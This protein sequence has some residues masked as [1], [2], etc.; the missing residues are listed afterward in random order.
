MSMRP[1]RSLVGRQDQIG[2]LQT[3]LGAAAQGEGGVL[4]LRGEPGIG[5]SALLDHL[6]GAVAAEFQIIRASGSE[7]ETELPFAALHQLCLPVLAH[8][9]GLTPPYRTAL[10]VAFGLA[11]GTPDPF[12]VGLGAL[13]LLAAA[14][15]ERPLVCVVDDAQWLDTASVRAL[16]F[17]ARR[18]AAEPIALL[19]AARP[20]GSARELERLPGLMVEGL[21]DAEAR[22][23][24]AAEKTVT[25]DERVRERILA[26]ARGNPLA[27]IEL[28][29]GGGFALPTPT[30]VA[31]RIAASFRARLSPLAAGARRLLL[32]AS[33]D[34]TGDPT[35]LWAAAQHVGIDL[36]A[37]GADAEASTL[38]EFDT[39]VRFCH[40]LARSAVYWAADQGRRNEAHRAL[41]EATDPVAAPDRRAWH[42]AQ[43]GTGPDE[44]VGA[45]PP[46]GGGAPARDSV[47]PGSAA[48]SVV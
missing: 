26:E 14:A 12:G 30:P 42:R 28:P 36:P 17:L 43:S 19:F 24:L 46:G 44:D 48:A 31:N 16:T 25:L 9:D 35:L 37:A 23:L 33:A 32:L 22:L 41:A 7:F 6:T 4:V 21:S 39:R 29:K 11:E 1:P 15:R 45:P 40:P 20:E 8:L 10:Q 5:K 38:V 3:V 27:L 18:L 2:R 34:P 47:R 13:E